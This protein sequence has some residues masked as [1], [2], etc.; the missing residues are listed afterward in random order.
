M[1][2]AKVTVTGEKAVSVTSPLVSERKN[3][4]KRGLQESLTRQV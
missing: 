2:K 1:A 3:Q 4:L